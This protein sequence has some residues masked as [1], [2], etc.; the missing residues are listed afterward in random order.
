M[1]LPTIWFAGSRRLCADY[2]VYPLFRKF[3]HFCGEQPA[4]P[5]FVPMPIYSALQ[6]PRM[7]NDVMGEKS[8][9]FL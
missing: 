1:P 6:R 5:I 2:A 4:S 8:L 7:F 9:Y 3:Q